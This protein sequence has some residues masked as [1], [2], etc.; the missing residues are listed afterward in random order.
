VHKAR[1]TGPVVLVDT[2]NALWKN[3][4]LSGEPETQRAAFILTAM[5]AMGVQAMAP[6]HRDLVQ[7]PDWLKAQASK[8]KVPVL[9]ANLVD[10]EG[11]LLFPASR[12]VEVGK[13]KVGLIGASPMGPLEK[14]AARGTPAVAAVLAEANKLRGQKVDLVV[15]LAAVPYADSLQLSRELGDAVDLIL[16]SHEARG[17]GAAQ[18]GEGNYVLPSGER[19]RQLGVLT[20]PLGTGPLLDGAEQARDEQTLSMLGSQVDM[21]KQRMDAA[22]DPETRTALGKTLQQFEERVSQVKARI[23]AGR[24]AGGRRMALEWWTLTSDFQE[25]KA[26]A[27]EVRRIEPAGAGH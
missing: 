4:G 20:V 17:P 5:G 7:G 11:K 18:K 13:S 6:G 2:G 10:A 12:V 16:Q 26:L 27:A 1:K 19:G 24:K 14:G 3:T 23:A 25:D 9:S 8:A 21:V 15:V 22:K